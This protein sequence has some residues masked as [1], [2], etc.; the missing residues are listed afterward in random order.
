MG[1]N[2]LGCLW[3]FMSLDVCGASCPWMS[4]GLHDLRCRADVLGTAHIFL[5]CIAFFKGRDFMPGERKKGRPAET[6]KI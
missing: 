4:V 6:V 1:L 2:G 3:G 5:F